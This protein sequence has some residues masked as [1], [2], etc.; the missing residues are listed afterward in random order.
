MEL[1]ASSQ[2]R[3]EL[4]TS[5]VLVGIFSSI[6]GRTDTRTKPRRGGRAAGFSPAVRTAGISPA[7]RCVERRSITSRRG[8]ASV[9]G[10]AG[11]RQGQAVGRHEGDDVDVV[12][13]RRVGGAAGQFQL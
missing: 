9:R 1:L 6:C 12:L 10:G 11:V 5:S 2:S 7:A 4:A 13:R 3:I 8:A